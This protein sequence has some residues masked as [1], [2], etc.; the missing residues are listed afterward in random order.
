MD[1]FFLTIIMIDYKVMYKKSIDDPESFWSEQAKRFL[2]WDESFTKADNC[3]KDEGTISWFASGKL[4]VS[5][6]S[7]LGILIKR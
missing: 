4:N 2:L 5:S 1:F 3:N 6:K 7:G